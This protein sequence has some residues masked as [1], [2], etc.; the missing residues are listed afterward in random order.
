MKTQIKNLMRIFLLVVLCLFITRCSN[1]PLSNQEATLSD[2]DLVSKMGQDK[3]S[4]KAIVYKTELSG[5]NEVPMRETDASG[6]AIVKISQDEETVQ[7]VV[8]V[9]NIENTRAAHF[10]KAPA[11]VNGAV[12]IGIFSGPKIEGVFSDKVTSGKITTES[13][14]DDGTT[15]LA[16]FI[17][18]IKDGNIYIN[19]HTDR[20]P[21]GELRGQL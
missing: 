10:H 18:D 13:F 17:Q 11:G 7:Y 15:K 5:N 2:N 4:A 6:H 20:Y 14:G 8:I 16:M 12:V 3:K 1:E 19:V 21:G 9:E